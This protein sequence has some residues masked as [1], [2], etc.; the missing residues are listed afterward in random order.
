MDEK[1]KEKLRRLGVSKGARNLKTAPKPHL[2]RIWIRP[3][4]RFA[5]LKTKPLSPPASSLFEEGFDPPLIDALLPGIYRQG[6]GQ[7]RLLRLDKVYPLTYQ[8]GQERLQDLLALSRPPRPFVSP[9]I[10][11]WLRPSSAIFSSSTP[12]PPAWPAQV[13]WL[14][15][16][17]PPF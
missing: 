4:G 6:D 2:C 3:N 15:W 7:R 14:S 16:S 10:R 11:A 8:H 17:A 5:K 13:R 1:L 12:K 9:A